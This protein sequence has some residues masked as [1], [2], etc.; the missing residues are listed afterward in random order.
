M[1]GIS[2]F[3]T[4]NIIEEA[5]TS[6]NT[7]TKTQFFYGPYN[8]NTKSTKNKTSSNPN[9]NNQTKVTVLKRDSVINQKKENN[10]DIQSM[11]CN[12]PH[13]THRCTYTRKL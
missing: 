11:L 9:N 7:V 1:A 4:L 12:Q 10:L 6:T 2:K 3:Q 13:D 5:D 8:N